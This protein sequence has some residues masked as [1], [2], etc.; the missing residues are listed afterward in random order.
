MLAALPVLSSGGGGGEG[1]RES[2]G[3]SLS[4]FLFPSACVSVAVF[5]E[6]AHAAL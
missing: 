2:R 3:F 5:L 4:P 6:V 1:G